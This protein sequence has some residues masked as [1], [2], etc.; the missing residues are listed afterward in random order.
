MLGKGKRICPVCGR[1]LVLRAP[2]EYIDSDKITIQFGADGKAYYPRTKPDFRP[3]TIYPRVG[4][5]LYSPYRYVPGAMTAKGIE[6]AIKKDKLSLFNP[7]LVLFCEKCNSR[8]SLNFNPMT[9]P[10]IL[11]CLVFVFALPFG[12]AVIFPELF[13]LWWVSVP[14]ILYGIFLL[15]VLGSLIYI[16]LFLSN[17]VPVD[18]YDALRVP[19]C[20][21]TLSADGLKKKYLRKSNIFSTNLAGKTFYLYLAKKFG[22][23]LKF[24]I[25][26]EQGEPDAL[27]ELIEQNKVSELSFEFEGKSVG[28]AVLVGIS[29]TEE[30]QEQM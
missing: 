21:L 18:K 17:F 14:L 22:D 12:Y 2:S 19:H 25:C 30:E 29:P 7:Y 28:K 24:S 26:G 4:A 8:L 10:E 13:G 5:K 15:A 20:E 9:T 1:A 11:V 6:Y 23:E 16:K 27:L 3:Y